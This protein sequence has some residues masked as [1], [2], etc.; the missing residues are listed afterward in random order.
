MVFV[1]LSFTHETTY[2]WDIYKAF[3]KKIRPQ[4]HKIDPPQV[5]LLFDLFYM[6]FP[7]YRREGA[8]T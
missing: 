8:I 3:G 2:P 6:I 7:Q 5:K 4:L 1:E